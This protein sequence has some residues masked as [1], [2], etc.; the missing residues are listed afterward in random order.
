MRAVIQRVSK[1]EVRVSETTV[2]EIDRGFLVLLGIATAD[3]ERDA[4]AIAGKIAGLRVFQDDADKMN[5]DLAA[6]D[7]A[8]LLVSQFTLIADVRKGRRPSFVGAAD[9]EE[10]ARLAAVAARAGTDAIM[11]AAQLSDAGFEVASGEFGA[12]MEVSLVNDGPVTIVI[13]STDG[14]IS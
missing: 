9:P 8:V 11:V 7:G 13:D 2:G 3:T 5:L 6:V 14:S 10:A 1:A 12:H 4:A